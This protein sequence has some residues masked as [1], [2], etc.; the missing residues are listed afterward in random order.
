MIIRFQA[1][2]VR[3]LIA[4]ARREKVDTLFLQLEPQ[5]KISFVKQD[6]EWTRLDA[7]PGPTW[8][9]H[10]RLELLELHNHVLRV[11]EK[12]PHKVEDTIFLDIR[13]NDNMDYCI[14][15]SRLEYREP[16][17]ALSAGFCDFFE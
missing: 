12:F 17:C 10:D 7:Q 4:D 2:Q 1:S 9:G 5:P 6:G 8:E 14:A 15:L 16:K 11:L 13:F 3:Q